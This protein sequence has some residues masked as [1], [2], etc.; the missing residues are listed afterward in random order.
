VAYNHT[1]YQATTK[2]V[3]SKDNDSSIS[4]FNIQIL[5]EAEDGRKYAWVDDR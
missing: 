1:Q 2:E 3:K 5:K 4:G